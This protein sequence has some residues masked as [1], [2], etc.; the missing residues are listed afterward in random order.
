MA[1]QSF[2]RG[3]QATMIPLSDDNPSSIRPYVT[4][5]LIGACAAVFVVQLMLGRNGHAAILAFGLVPVEL[6]SD[7]VP[8]PQILQVP[9]VA[10]IFTSMFMHGGIMHFLGNMLY[11]WIFSDNVE[12]SM[13]HVRFVFFYLL[14]G[15]AAAL[16]FVVGRLLSGVA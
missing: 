16:A 1:Q 6:M 10:T 3:Q 7:A 14:C 2:V 13:G 9:D 11:L 5:F 8:Y 4:W 12:D 15:I